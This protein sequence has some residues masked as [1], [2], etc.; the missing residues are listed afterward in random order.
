MSIIYF[1]E[2]ALCEVTRGTDCQLFL[3][4]AP[5]DSPGSCPVPNA[6]IPMWSSK[7][8]PAGG[9]GSVSPLVRLLTCASQREGASP[10]RPA[11]N[12]NQSQSH[13]VGVTRPT[14]THSFLQH[15]YL[16]VVPAAARRGPVAPATL[17]HHN[18]Q[19]QPSLLYWYWY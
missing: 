4:C 5:L 19:A 17:K 7:Q 10:S 6:R 16:P 9:R 8:L 12:Q 2:S 11:T 13:Q 3:D 1:S 15:R 18:Q 14:W